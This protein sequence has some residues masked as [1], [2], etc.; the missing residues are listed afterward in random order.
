MD[1]MNYFT[2]PIKK[3]YELVKLWFSSVNTTG[4]LQTLNLYCF[5]KGFCSNLQ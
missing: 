3:I 4:K 5:Q 2:N 1:E